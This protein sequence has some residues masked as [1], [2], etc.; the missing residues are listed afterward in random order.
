MIW[1]SESLVG[2]LVLKVLG[3]NMLAETIDAREEFILLFKSSFFVISAKKV[4]QGTAS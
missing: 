2:P 4:V 3:T 1:T